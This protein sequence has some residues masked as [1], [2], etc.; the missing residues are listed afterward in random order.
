MTSSPARARKPFPVHADDPSSEESNMY[1]T[2]EDKRTIHGRTR[3]IRNRLSGE[4]SE[5]VLEVVEESGN[6]DFLAIYKSL[7]RLRPLD[8]D[9][10]M[11]A[12]VVR[13]LLA[14]MVAAG[15][16]GLDRIEFD[17]A[18]TVRDWGGTSA[19][20]ADAYSLVGPADT[21]DRGISDAIVIYLDRLG[22]AKA[23]RKA[24]PGDPF[25][26]ILR[27]HGVQPE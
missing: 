24:K 15:D 25:A 14:K 3:T 22:P 16:Q 21:T 6:D 12:R 18:Q 2:D 17:C 23:K 19:A 5:A 26:E 4:L 11:T 13:F 1:L 10:A 8:V 27:R 7:K 20:I 9:R